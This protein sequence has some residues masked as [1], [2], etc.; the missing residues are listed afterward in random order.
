MVKYPNLRAELL[1]ELRNL[2]DTDYQQRV[3]INGSAPDGYVDDFCS[4]V[5]FFYDDTMLARDTRSTV[6]VILVDDTE[7]GP[8][9]AVIQAIDQMFLMHG[10]KLSDEAYLAKPEWGVVVDAARIAHD[11]LAGADIDPNTKQI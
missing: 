10:M 3:W 2:S 7:V 11:A 6:G 4:V 5:E 8:I 9:R 1:D